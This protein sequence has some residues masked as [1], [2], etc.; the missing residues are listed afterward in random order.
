MRP[1]VNN[2]HVHVYTCAGVTSTGVIHGKEGQTDHCMCKEQSHCKPCWACQH[3]H[4]VAAGRYKVLLSKFPLQQQH[5][6][7]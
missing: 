3:F 2:V 4:W 1:A 7:H 5:C 6:C